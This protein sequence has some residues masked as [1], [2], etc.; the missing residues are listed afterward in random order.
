MSSDARG[1]VEAIKYSPLGRF[2]TLPMRAR[3]A[4][5]PLGMSWLRGLG[6]ALTSREYTTP[7]YDHHE[8]GVLAAAAAIAQVSGLPPAQVREYAQELSTDDVIRA[9]Y[10]DRL[11][12]TRLRHVR[13]PHF[14]LG[15]GLMTYM[16]VR[17]TGARFV[18]EAGTDNGFG[19]LAVLRALQRNHPAGGA[20]LVTVDIREDRGDFLVGDENGMVERLTGD[21]VRIL[22]EVREPVDVLLH[23]TINEPVHTRAQFAAALPR[24]SPRA[25]IQAAW[26]SREFMEFCE[27]NGFHYLEY[28]A[29]PVNHWYPGG[30]SG[31]A[32]RRAGPATSDVVHQFLG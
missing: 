19:S 28:M 25:A 6:W 26:F 3:S 23:D 30:R 5:G 17:A 12:R 10:Q 27:A 15:R 21:S 29:R 31:L 9:R 20:R 8:L 18:F 32:M 24:L 7:A 4:L 11:S 1:L 13:D 22:G 2:A 16:L 14:R